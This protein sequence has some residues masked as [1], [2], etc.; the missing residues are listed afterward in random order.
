MS[1]KSKSRLNPIPTGPEVQYQWLANRPAKLPELPEAWSAS[2]LATPFGDSISPEPNSSQLAVARVESATAGTEGWMRVR[3]YLTHDQRYFDFLFISVDDPDQSFKSEWYWIDSSVSG[4]IAQVYGPFTT[5]LRVPV[6]QFLKNNGAMWGN[7]YPLMCTGRNP[8]I[9]CDHWVITTPGAQADHGSWYSVRRDTGHVLRV[10]TMDSTNPMMLPFVGACFMANF[11]SFEERVSVET[12]KLVEVVKAGG[13]VARADYWNPLV[14][15]QDVMRAFKFPLAY[16]KC[17]EADIQHVLPG[18]TASP[19]PEPPPPAWSKKLYIE[20]WA[21]AVDLIPYRVRV[22]YS[23]PDGERSKQQSI[24]IGWGQ[25]P[26]AGSYFKRTD[27]CLHPGGTDMP[28]FEWNDA[29]GWGDPKF[30][31]PSLA[32]I[33]PPFPDWPSRDHA[34]IMGQ[35][36]GN[37]DFGLEK[38]EVLNILAGMN[39]GAFGALGTFWVWFLENNVGMLFCEGNFMNSLS[40]TLQILDYTLFEKDAP[41]EDSDFSNP[42]LNVQSPPPRS[43]RNVSGHFT[44]PRSKD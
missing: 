4:Q 13:S 41:V 9:D 11:A 2:V 38:D 44:H 30:C 29:A 26:G 43:S 40:H 25:T 7:R 14:T 19:R 27:T 42:C 5:T 15:Q 37:R 28:Y 1:E 31:L 20:A 24:F 22:C 23:F 10:F 6:R 33:G 39:P 18:F 3:L 21:L 36:K 16:A 8:G 17:T 32:G 34:V 35:I 12:R